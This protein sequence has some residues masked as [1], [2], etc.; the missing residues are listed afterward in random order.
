MYALIK[1]FFCTL[2]MTISLGM[3]DGVAVAP[4]FSVDVISHEYG[5]NISVSQSQLCNNA[6]QW[7]FCGEITTAFLRAALLPLGQSLIKDNSSLAELKK[8]GISFVLLANEVLHILNHPSA[9]HTIDA[10]W[11]I[12][13]TA[14]L[15]SH[16][17]KA[18]ARLIKPSDKALG[19]DPFS[20]EKNHKSWLEQCNDPAMR[21]FAIAELCVAVLTVASCCDADER[22]VDFCNR[23]ILSLMRLLRARSGAPEF[24]GELS[25]YTGLFSAQLAYTLA[26]IFIQPFNA[27]LRYVVPNPAHA[28]V[29]PP[30]PPP[31][32]PVPQP[33]GPLQHGVNIALGNAPDD[34]GDLHLF[35]RVPRRGQPDLIMDNNNCPICFAGFNALIPAPGLVHARVACMPCGHVYCAHEISAWW[36]QHPWGQ[37]MCM[38]GCH[39]PN[40]VN[41]RDLFRSLI[42]QYDVDPVAGTVTFVRNGL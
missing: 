24:N 22:R 18:I 6:S 42:R 17:A 16:V 14:Q 5:L 36:N 3:R 1:S 7:L 29:V 2:V 23:S 33:A 21:Y 19:V 41:N 8:A 30:P 32:P 31:A 20:P 28:V 38:Q 15:F 25:I 9:D 13:D 35:V 40:G 34:M 11:A 37:V 27:P 4:A 26:K 10:V 12:T 39:R